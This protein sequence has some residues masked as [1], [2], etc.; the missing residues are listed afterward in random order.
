MSA[1]LNLAAVNTCNIVDTIELSLDG[2]A[3][4]TVNG[5]HG[6]R[7]S[8]GMITKQEA[9]RLPRIFCPGQNQ[10]L[11]RE[12]SFYRGTSCSIPT[13]R[14]Q[15]CLTSLQSVKQSIS[16]QEAHI[17]LWQ[18]ITKSATSCRRPTIKMSPVTA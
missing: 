8:T 15:I 2:T 4:V 18:E 16:H 14:R 5:F 13:W 12:R 11:Q 1:S 7:A 6:R 10:R 9:A 3:G 17:T